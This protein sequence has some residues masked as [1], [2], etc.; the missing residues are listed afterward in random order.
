[1]GAHGLTYLRFSKTNKIR[2]PQIFMRI[3][4]KLLRY[5]EQAYPEKKLVF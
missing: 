5:I 4:H 1:M 2:D 3:H